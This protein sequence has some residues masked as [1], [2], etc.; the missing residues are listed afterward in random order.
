MSI[1]RVDL[2]TGMLLTVALILQLTL[3]VQL[4]EQWGEFNSRALGVF[5]PLIAGVAIWSWIHVWLKHLPMDASTPSVRQQ[6]KYTQILVAAL[7]AA[8][9]LQGLLARA[10]VPL[11]NGAMGLV[12][13]GAM[14]TIL[15]NRTSK[16]RKNASVGIRN[17]WTLADDEV[18][19]RTH[20]LLA[21]VMVLGG[22]VLIAVALL[23]TNHQSV[24]AVIALFFIGLILVRF[25]SFC[26]YR[27]LHRS[28]Q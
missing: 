26:V 27:R 6:L 17:T 13:I 19:L 7:F 11:P 15:G 24:H 18:W 23:R 3:Y 8:M 28:S 22:I 25:Y 20:R 21:R 12:V 14:F 10:D 9:P 16:L 5:I 1:Q 4:N 2:W